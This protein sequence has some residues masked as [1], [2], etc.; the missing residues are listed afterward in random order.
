MEEYF[1]VLRKCMVIG[2]WIY[3]AIQMWPAAESRDRSPFLWFLI[4]LFAFYIPFAMVGFLP[5]VLLLMLQVRTG[6][7]ISD[8]VFSAVGV[9]AFVAGVTLG[10]A[11]LRYARN[12]A[13][14]PRKR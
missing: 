11:C 9:G 4:G 6:M 3:V 10:I 5:P 1:G 14:A 7:T 12:H 8:S 13:A 2:I